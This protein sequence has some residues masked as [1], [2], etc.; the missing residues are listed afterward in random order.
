MASSVPNSGVSSYQRSH[1]RTDTGVGAWH[2]TGLGGELSSPISNPVVTRRDVVILTTP[3]EVSGL[4]PPTSTLRT[5][6]VHPPE[7]GLP[8][9]TSW[10]R[11]CIPSTLPQVS[12]HSRKIR[13]VK[14]TPSGPSRRCRPRWVSPFAVG[15]DL[16]KRLGRA[17]GC[18]D[19]NAFLTVV[20]PRNEVLGRHLFVGFKRTITG[21][22]GRSSAPRG[23]ASA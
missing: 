11:R 12:S 3:V 7:Q 17:D 1:L 16:G 21:S 5:S 13:S 23:M 19:R 10:Y 8:E 9:R 22:D 4:E 15:P 2:Q 20:E 6:F 18:L 14:V